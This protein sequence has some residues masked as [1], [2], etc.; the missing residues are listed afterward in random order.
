MC[1]QVCSEAIKFVPAGVR[2]KAKDD[3]NLEFKSKIM[4]SFVRYSA[5]THSF[6]PFSPHFTYIYLVG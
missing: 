5:Y 1:T 3:F 4:S 6:L 2:F